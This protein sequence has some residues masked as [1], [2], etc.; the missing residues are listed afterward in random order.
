MKNCINIVTDSQ[1]FPYLIEYNKGAESNDG[2]TTTDGDDIKW[3]K[4]E[5]KNVVRLFEK[6]TNYYRVKNDWYLADT[7]YDD[8]LNTYIPELVET[9]NI[10]VYIP[11]H[12]ISAYIK[13][14]KYA[15]TINTWING[16][17][18]DLGTFI[19]KPTDTYAIP[20]GVIKRGNNEYY[21]CIDFDI[22]DPFYLMYSDKWAQ[23]RQIVCNEPRQLNNTGSTIYV[24]LFVIDEHDNRYIIKDGTIGGCTNFNIAN[25]DDYL[26]LKISMNSNPHGVNFELSVNNEYDWLLDYLYETYGITASHSDIKYELILKSK[27]SAIIGP[28]MSYT[29]IPNTRN[30]NGRYMPTQVMTYNYIANETDPTRS[31]IKTFFSDWQYFEEGWS[32]VGS[33]TVYK[34]YIIDV[35]EYNENGTEKKDKNGNVATHKETHYDEIFSLVSNE[36]PIT[37]EIFSTM[38]NGGMEKIIDVS[39]MEINTYNVV[40]KIENKIVQIE[41]PNESKS[42]IMQPIFFRVKDTE[43]LTLHPV[44]TENISINLDDYK[45]KVDKFTLLIEGCRFE[46]IGSNSYGIL[47]KIGANKL[48]ETAVTGTYYILNENDELV[49]TGK[50]SCVR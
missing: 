46:Q 36:I 49:T 14:I 28:T 18:V 43:T 8:M 6:K 27:D 44:V 34:Q 30:A 50:Y 38:V 47:F 42:N 21:E 32:F 33:M 9:S 17:K 37:Q 20:T 29:E 31:G 19:F 4:D 22:I 13:H 11:T 35:I 10:K 1:Q 23:F 26:T 12:S 16:V 39:D 15:I 2:H 40:N 25:P 5:E 3:Y 45:T 41:R 7:I 48:P 24:S